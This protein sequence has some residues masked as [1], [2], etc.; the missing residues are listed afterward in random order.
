MQCLCT[1]VKIYA[2]CALLVYFVYS[3][4]P[5]CILNDNAQ[6]VQCLCTLAKLYALCA[7]LVCF[8]YSVHPVCTLCTLEFL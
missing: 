2:N 4:H 8:V 1:L 5:L 6:K 3:V 7:L